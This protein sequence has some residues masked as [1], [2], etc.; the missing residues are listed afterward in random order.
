MSLRRKTLLMPKRCRSPRKMNQRNRRRLNCSI[1]DLFKTS[2]G[3]I[4]NFF[5]TPLALIRK[6]SATPGWCSFDLW[7]NAQQCRPLIRKLTMTAFPQPEFEKH[8][9][10]TVLECNRKQRKTLRKTTCLSLKCSCRKTDVEH[11][12]FTTFS[13]TKKHLKNIMLER[14]GKQGKTIR[15]IACFLG[16]MLL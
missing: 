11:R 8:L 14:S 15:K 7:E 2:A 13:Q 6:F 5:F 12:V 3:R 1:Y 4:S 9:E 16:V 10:N